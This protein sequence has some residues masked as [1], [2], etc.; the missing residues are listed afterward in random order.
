MRHEKANNTAL[1]AIGMPKKKMRFDESPYSATSQQSAL[2][3]AF[4]SKPATATSMSVRPKTKRV[5]L[6]DLLFLMEQEKD[7]K[8]SP[9]LWKAYSS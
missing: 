3:S 8:R 1:L 4:G 2:S 6:R 5:H 9:L 7:L